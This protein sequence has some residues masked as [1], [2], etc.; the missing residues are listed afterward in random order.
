MISVGSAAFSDLA[1]NANIDGSDRNNTVTFTVDT[2]APSPSP[3]PAPSAN[4]NPTPDSLRPSIAISDDDPDDSL[5]AG[6]TST[7]SFRLSEPSTDFLQSDVAVSGGSLSNWTADSSSSYTAS[8]TP[9]KNSTTDGV[10]SVASGVFSNSA[11]N[12]NNDDAD[13]NNSVTFTI[14]TVRPTIAITMTI[15]IIP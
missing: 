2:T 6:E 3:A 15:P 1:G 5:A 7:L 14:D 11:G 9:S 4:P 12:T 10:L 13:P 8:F